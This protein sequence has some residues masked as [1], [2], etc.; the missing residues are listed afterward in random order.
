VSWHIQIKV[1]IAVYQHSE[2]PSS[3]A[4]RETSH[5][6]IAPTNATRDSA[7]DRGGEP[8]GQR[9]TDDASIGENLKVIICDSPKSPSIPLPRT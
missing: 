5:Q 3:G 9:T 4:K 7:K 1:E 8:Q 2:E 6:R